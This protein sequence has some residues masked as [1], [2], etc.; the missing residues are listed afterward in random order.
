M[1]GRSGALFDGLGPLRDKSST[2]ATRRVHRTVTLAEFIIPG[3]DTIIGRYIDP[4]VV[5][6]EP[7]F[8][9][10]FSI[11][12]L[13]TLSRRAS[14]NYLGKQIDLSGW[15]SK[16]TTTTE[17]WVSQEHVMIETSAVHTASAQ[18]Q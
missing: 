15:F 11:C 3:L 13:L 12:L 8:L 7:E 4:A 1:I 18:M 6:R 17:L 10:K 2:V 5:A 9:A 14:I 16:F